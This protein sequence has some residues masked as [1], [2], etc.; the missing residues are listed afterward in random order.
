LN[1]AYKFTPEK[2]T[3]WLSLQD[4]TIIITDTWIGISQQDQEKIRTRFRKKST[5]NNNGY[6]LWLYMVK[7][8][9]EKLGR[10]IHL[11]ST[12]KKWTTFTI[13]MS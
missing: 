6:G 4:N 7:L 10:T 2:W 1:N 12:E 3:I 5:E 11:H 13:T 8:L 9:S